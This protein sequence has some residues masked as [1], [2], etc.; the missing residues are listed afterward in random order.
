MLFGWSYDFVG[1][2][3]ETAALTVARAGGASAPGP[4]LAEVVATLATARKSGA[5]RAS[6]PIWLDALDATGRWALLKLVTGGL[7]VGVSARLAKLAL[8]EYGGQ[9]AG[10][11]RGGLARAVPALRGLSRGWTGAGRGRPPT[12]A[13][14]S[15]R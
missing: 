14:Y 7:R 4:S 3:A 8:A 15:A 1:D 5:A 10:R 13:P 12:Q 9:R 11:D 2:L 6:S